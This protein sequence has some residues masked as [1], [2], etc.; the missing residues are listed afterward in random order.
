[1]A[2]LVTAALVV[3]VAA[4]I[5]VWQW[6]EASRQRERARAL[7]EAALANAQQADHP[8]TAL[9]LSADA[10]RR[11]VSDG[12]RYQ[13]ANALTHEGVP[14]QYVPL[15]LSPI[16]LG[17][18]PPH[19]DDVQFAVQHQSAGTLVVAKGP[20]HQPVAGPKLDP[21]VRISA[22]AVSGDGSTAVYGAADSVF[23][24][25]TASGA[26]RPLP[27]A[28]ATVDLVGI[29]PDGSTVAAIDGANVLHLW[30][31]DGSN[32]LRTD[33]PYVARAL[34]VDGPSSVVVISDKG[35]V[36]RWEVLDEQSA[37]PAPFDGQETAVTVL[38]STPAGNLLAAAGADGRVVVWDLQSRDSAPSGRSARRWR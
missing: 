7:Q 17:A 11:D 9:L 31:S 19:A 30:S 21:S 3:T 20:T 27:P 15:G 33:L 24:V 32:R 22:L 13:L 8:D 25:D 2:V 5:A 37:Q 36:D 1:M 4:G 12:T 34:L 18:L 16:A 28:G 10:Y 38:A 26:A 6:R 23:V 29:S 35:E 14:Y